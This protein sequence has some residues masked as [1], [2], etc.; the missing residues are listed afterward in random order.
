LRAD[1]GTRRAWVET[2]VRPLIVIDELETIALVGAGARPAWGALDVLDTL[3]ACLP[4]SNARMIG[5]SNVAD[6]YLDTALTRDGRLPIV[7]LPATLDARGVA[8][9]VAT[10][11]A[12]VP[13][14]APEAGA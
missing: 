11:L 6:R 7:Q 2:G 8:A 1:G 9:L 13:L 3:L 12:D 10:C 4:R 5:I 14:A